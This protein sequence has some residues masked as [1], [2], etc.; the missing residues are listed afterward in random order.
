[1]S[2]V[3]IGI[4]MRDSL[5]TIKIVLGALSDEV[6]EYHSKIIILD[7]NSLDGSPEAIEIMMKNNLLKTFDIELKRVGALIGERKKNIELMRRKLSEE[8]GT[9]YLMFV[10]SDVLLPPRAIPKLIKEMEKNKKLGMM[11]IVHFPN[12]SHVKM[13]A[14]MLRTALAKKIK[15]RY[16][17]E[18]CDCIN[19]ARQLLEM[20]YKT[21]HHKELIARHL[22]AF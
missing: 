14:A 16:D 9:K 19:A 6:Q 11:G 4:L 7:N 20:G 13:G 21:E 3:T 10:D 18:G 5:S 1:M 15:W 8:C 22:M 17:N 2:D 12:E